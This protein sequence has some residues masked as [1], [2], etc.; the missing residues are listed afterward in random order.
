MTT[1]LLIGS[2]A[3]ASAVAEEA[4][5]VG[6]LEYLGSMVEADGEL[7]DGMNLRTPV[8]NILLQE[9]RKD[10]GPESEKPAEEGDHE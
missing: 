1:L 6:F 9:I 5:P 10:G 8:E 4:L 3:S 7:I 2:G